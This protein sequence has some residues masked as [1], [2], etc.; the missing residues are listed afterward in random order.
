MKREAGLPL[1]TG[2]LAALLCHLLRRVVPLGSHAAVRGL[3]PQ[4]R[5]GRCRSSAARAKSQ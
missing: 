1:C 4:V 5:D 2:V 3:S